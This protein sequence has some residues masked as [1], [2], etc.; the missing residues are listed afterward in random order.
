MQLLASLFPGG[1]IVSG[2]PKDL[3]RSFSYFT[4][5][6]FSWYLKVC[7]IATREQQK[8]ETWGLQEG[9]SKVLQAKMKK[10]VGEIKNVMQVDSARAM[11]Q[12]YLFQ[13]KQC[14]YLIQIKQELETT[15]SQLKNE[16]RIPHTH[17]VRLHPPLLFLFNVLVPVW[18]CIGHV[19]CF[20]MS[21]KFAVMVGRKLLS[22]SCNPK[23]STSYCADIT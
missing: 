6:G 15:L 16:A 1:R 18:S 13:E 12:E 21:T 17:R 11:Y 19:Q 3:S 10:A 5:V 8:P 9:L 14:L 7:E 20:F 22:P 23:V 4:M 2:S